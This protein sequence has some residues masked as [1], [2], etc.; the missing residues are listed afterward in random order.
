MLRHFRIL[1]FAA[2][3][4]TLFACNP[5]E[6]SQ[7]PISDF[8]KIAD[9]ST[10]KIS[11]DGKYISYLKAYNKKENLFIRSLVDGK[12]QAATSFT[13]YPVRG[14]YFWTFN[15]QIVF[16]QDL[17]GDDLL[18]LYTLDVPSLKVKNI[19]SLQK[20]RIYLLNRNK[21]DPDVITIRMNKRDPANFDIYKLNTR[22]G[23]L[24]PYLINPGN[25]T[26]WCPD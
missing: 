25:I 9:K 3:A 23:E 21:E 5:H 16:F 14:D 8:F 10:F 20:V 15:N 19:L 1:I 7:I 26:E 13:D 11:P 6:T 12:E 18:K 22:T 4:G 24:T 2:F 17:I